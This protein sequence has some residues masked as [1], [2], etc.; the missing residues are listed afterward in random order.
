MEDNLNKSTEAI[1]STNDT[2]VDYIEALKEMKENSV[3]K[4]EYEKLKD[5]NRKLLNAFTNGE[6]ISIPQEVKPNIDELRAKVM[7]EDQTNL[8]YITNVLALRKAVIENGDEDPFVP[9]G[10]KIAPTAEDRI[11]AQNVADVLQECVDYAQGDSQLFT[12]ELQRRTID[13]MPIRR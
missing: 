5:E 12:N 2:N 13:V 3:S 8:E 7:S 9:V 10:S 11:K 4:A 1:N 6:T